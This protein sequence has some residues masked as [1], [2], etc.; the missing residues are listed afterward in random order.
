MAITRVKDGRRVL[1]GQIS[2]GTYSGFEN[3]IQLFDGKYTTGYR[4]VSFRIAPKVPSATYEITAKL[5]TEPKSTISQWHWQDVQEV[6]WAA[7]NITNSSSDLEYQNI[8]EENMII[9]DLW[10]G[11]YYSAEAID[12]NYEIIL[13]KYNLSDWDGAGVIVNNLAQAGPV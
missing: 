11:M 12:V 1:T 5:S 3:R 4:V 13:E 9:E 7:W 6:A 8:R 10:I 2:T